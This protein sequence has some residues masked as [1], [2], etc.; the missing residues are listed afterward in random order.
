MFFVASKL[1]WIV[2]APLNLLALCVLAG[3]VISGA[4]PR[5]GR[6]LAGG[7]ALLILVLGLSPAGLALISPLEQRFSRPPPDM[8][9]PYGIIV[10]GG[11]I[12]DLMTKAHGTLNLQ[13]GASRVTEAVLLA[14]R[15]PGARLFYTGGSADLSGAD[16]SSQE[17]EEA[18]DFWIAAGI[19]PARIGVESRSR[20][21]DENARFS[22]DILKPT[23]AQTWLLVTSAYH[24]PR[25]MGLFRKSGFRVIA[26]PV[27][28][29]AFG[30]A[31][32]FRFIRKSLVGLTIFDTALHEW[33]GLLA[34]WASGRIDELFPAP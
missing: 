14:R 20:N 13:D 11:G 5:A 31:R 10:L 7:A 8:P 32:D 4:R 28:Y 29:R 21:T 27:D 3:A 1:L 9:A 2:T 23:A 25:S 18:R 24:M 34:Y 22:A 30:D 33:V 15:F 17:A 19:D 12:D 26:D 6:Q 16:E